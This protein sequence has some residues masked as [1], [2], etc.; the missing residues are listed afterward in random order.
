MHESNTAMNANITRTIGIGMLAASI[1]LA[2][3]FGSASTSAATEIQAVGLQGATSAKVE[4]D[5]G[6]GEL[7]LRNVTL[8]VVTT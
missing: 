7:S 6:Q 4:I 2:T 3:G 8:E 5:M 1:P